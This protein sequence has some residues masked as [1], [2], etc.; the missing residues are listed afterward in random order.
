MT[1][2]QRICKKP[3]ANTW[4]DALASSINWVAH[5]IEGHGR[6]GMNVLIPVDDGAAINS[7][8]LVAGWSVKSGAPFCLE[9]SPCLRVS[10][11]QM[12]FEDLEKFAGAVAEIIGSGRNSRY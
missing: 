4:L 1:R 9:F 8:L 7:H 12:P 6:S 11:S 3:R 5:V 2:L 10:V